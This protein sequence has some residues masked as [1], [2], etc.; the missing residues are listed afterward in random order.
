MPQQSHPLNPPPDLPPPSGAPHPGPLAGL[1]GE[2]GPASGEL[3]GRETEW[4]RAAHDRLLANVGLIIRGKEEVIRL[5]LVALLSEGHL[6]LE[7]V[8]GVGKTSLA[9]S[10]AESLNAS[11]HRVQ[12]TPDLLPSDITGVSIWNQKTNEFEFRAGPVFA[13]V[14]LA[15]EINRASPKTQSALL[16]VMEERQV[17]VDGVAHNPPRPFV[18]IATQNPVDLDGTY[19]LPEAQLDR[20]MIR[21]SVGYPDEEAEVQLATDRTSGFSGQLRLQPVLSGDDV[22]AMIQMASR[23]FVAPS[24]YRYV[25]RLVAATRSLPE[26]RLGVSPRGTLALLRGAQTRAAADGRGWVLPDDI[27][28]LALPVL[29]HR[30]V[31]SPEAELSGHTAAQVL[32][33]L[34]AAQPVPRTAEDRATV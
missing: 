16:E 4:F 30:M 27:Q 28:T 21:A 22:Q 18:V 11:W 10:L 1:V 31:L 13:S 17:T 19:R 8:P 32:E 29:C 24:L 3:S 5:A 34:L 7:D 14:V 2:S 9:R 26:L 25:V 33:G 23:V 12:F 15:D 6:L 20:F